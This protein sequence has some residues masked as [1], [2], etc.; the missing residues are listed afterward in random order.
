MIYLLPNNFETQ[1][2]YYIP[3]SPNYDAED[4]FLRAAEGEHD[5]DEALQLGRRQ[6]PRRGPHSPRTHHRRRRRRFRVQPARQQHT[7]W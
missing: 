2:A 7:T 6:Q 1:G 4:V 3:G 5:D